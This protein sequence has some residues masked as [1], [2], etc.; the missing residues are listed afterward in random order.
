M[1]LKFVEKESE[2]AKKQ[3]AI[4]AERKILEGLKAVPVA[5][6]T[7]EALENSKEEVENYQ[8]ALEKTE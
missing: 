4:E 7:F 8:N 6:T 1:E 5:Q 2:L 3:A